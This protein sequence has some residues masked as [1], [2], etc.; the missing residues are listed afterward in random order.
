M[1]YPNTWLSLDQ[2]ATYQIK[3]QGELDK[4]WAIHFDDGRRVSSLV[5][6]VERGVTILTGTVADQPALY[7]WLGK[8]RDLSLALLSVKRIESGAV[9]A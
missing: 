7:G 9:S 1:E 3:V 5:I 2:S 8:L 4:D 6:T